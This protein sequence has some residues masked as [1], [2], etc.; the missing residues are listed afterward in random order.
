M[1][2]HVLHPNPCNIVIS[3][4]HLVFASNNNVSFLKSLQNFSKYTTNICNISKVTPNTNIVDYF[5]HLATGKLL[6][7]LP[8]NA[9]TAELEVG[10]KALAEVDV[11]AAIATKAIV[12][13]IVNTILLVYIPLVLKLCNLDSNRDDLTVFL[14]RLVFFQRID[15]VVVV[16]VA[17][18]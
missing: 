4:F 8:L 16:A 12:F 14:S 18:Q 3:S 1:T 2:L 6:L 9:F 13:F 15:V 17:S 11:A 10:T 5:S 7:A